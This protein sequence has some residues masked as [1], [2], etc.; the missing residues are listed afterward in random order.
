MGGLGQGAG[1]AA[2]ACPSKSCAG[3]ASK[4]PSWSLP[5]GLDAVVSTVPL[6]SGGATDLGWSRDGGL[7][8][9]S[10][11]TP[12]DLVATLASMVQSQVL[13]CLHV[14]QP[15]PDRGGRGDGIGFRL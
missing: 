12:R 15:D 10:R 1:E 13:I 11:Q 5:L 4:S 8:L 6:L 3:E 2:P 7:P 9:A 14:A